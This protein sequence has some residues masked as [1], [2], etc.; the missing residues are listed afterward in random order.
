MRFS[1]KARREPSDSQRDGE[2]P[3][4]HEHKED[5]RPLPLRRNLTAGPANYN[6]LEAEALTR[7]RQDPGK[8]RNSRT[9]VEG[10]SFLIVIIIVLVIAVS[11][12]DWNSDYE[13]DYE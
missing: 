13:H 11:H 8:L 5:T 12:S 6:L 3:Q 9:W 10:A 7:A 1:P 4:S 2:H